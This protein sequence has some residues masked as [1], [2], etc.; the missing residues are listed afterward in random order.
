MRINQ[1]IARA[2]VT[3]RRKAD[4]L[5][6]NGNVKINGVVLTQPGYDVQET[7]AVEVNGRLLQG[8]PP[9][10]YILLHKPYGVITSVSDEKGRPTVMDFVRDVDARLFPVGRLD[11]N[12]TGA[13]LLTND[14][15]LAYRVTHPKHQL[16]KTYRALVQGVV[17]DKQL[18][19][20][21]SGVDIG[22]YVTAPARVSILR[23]QG[24]STLLEL[25][26][27]EG[28]NRQVRKMLNAV[29]HPVKEL[30]RIA[31][32]EVRLG[33]LAVGQY[34]K[35]RPEEIRYLQTF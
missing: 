11:Y 13:L 29:D 17:S 6:Q 21:R 5:I 7:D 32:G 27:C 9:P 2:G 1:Y 10:A 20:L 30:A 26:I 35:L 19:H 8:A 3:S 34:R 23:C 28:R 14:G 18:A 31:I 15:A 22:G 33:H 4:V 16:Y 12:T 24:Q 25:S